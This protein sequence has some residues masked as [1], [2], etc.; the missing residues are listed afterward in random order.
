MP[1]YVKGRCLEIGSGDGV[2]TNFLKKSCKE[3]F[4]IDLSEK[5]IQGIKKWK[6]CS[7]INFIL[8]DARF[9]PFKDH[10]FDT[11]CAFEIIEHLPGYRDQAMFL[12]E[13]TR[14]LSTGGVFLISTPNKLL[15]RLYCKILRE[16]HSTHFSEL[17]YFQF[18]SFLKIYFSAVKIYGQF[19][20]VSPFYKFYYVRLVHRFLSK[21]VP[22]CKGLFGVCRK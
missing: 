22:F 10:S 1:Q 14:V 21:L 6:N 11:I 9:L 2:W 4:S 3:L 7:G 20:W 15:F 12:H 16:K 13:V 8:C 18:K 19:G 5:R 17:S